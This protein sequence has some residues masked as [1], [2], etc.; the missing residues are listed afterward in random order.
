MGSLHISSREWES[1]TFVE[2]GELM[3]GV[4]VDKE[5]PPTT[6]KKLN[7]ATGS[8]MHAGI[9]ALCKERRGGG[10]GVGEGREN[11]MKNDESRARA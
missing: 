9:R 11:C 4:V 6:K 10:G 2:D 1:G 5:G 7:G 3:M 8:T